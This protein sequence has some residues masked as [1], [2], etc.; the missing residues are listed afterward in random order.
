MDFVDNRV[1]GATGTVR[2]GAVFANKDLSLTPGLFGRIRILG[3]GKYKGLL[4]PEEAVGSDQDRRVVFIVDA[5]N[6]IAI[7]P[8]RLGPRIDGYRVVRDGLSGDET[9]VINGLMRVRPGIQVEPK[10]T[11]LPPS[12]ERNGS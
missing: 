11:T 4:V 3:S 5:Q 6:K 1:D 8:V 7:K 10:A 2:G 9:I 12:R